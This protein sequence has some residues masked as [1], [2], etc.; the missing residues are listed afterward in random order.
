MIK[1][2]NGPIN[3]A[4]LKGNINGIEKNIYLFMDT[5][6]NLD[7]ETR[8]DSFDSVDISYYLYKMIKE[9]TKP[10]DFFFEIRLSELRQ[11]ITNKRDIYIKE[12][13]N[14]FKSEF[15]IKKTENK[16][17][18]KYSKSNQNVKLHYLDIR[19]HL[20]LFDLIDDVNIHI[21]KYINLLKLNKDIDTENKSKYKDKII[22]YIRKIKNKVKLLT[23]YK[24]EVL[25]SN[26]SDYDKISDT[27]KYYLNKIINK[28][29]DLDLK[30]KINEFIENYYLEVSSNL[31][32]SLYKLESD[33]ENF[34]LEK[35]NS[36]TDI[37]D[38]IK[39]AIIDLY[40]IFTDGFLLRRIL[41]KNYIRRVIIYSGTQHSLN[42]IHFL[43]KYYNFKIIKIHNSVE[44]NTD[45][46]TKQISNAIYPFS[47]YKLFMEKEKK[48]IQCINWEILYGGKTNRTNR[49]K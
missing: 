21:N 38:F 33:I 4:H 18:V 35:I 47:I 26:N 2:I 6:N 45:K 42:Y 49:L 41:D 31:N 1:Y 17:I 39:E 46:L 19:D 32:S 20:N 7:N 28:Y 27:E 9:T 11:P 43:V 37:I 24:N 3:F 34:N 23:Q 44:K 15:V 14:L 48:Y 29:I 5:H 10:L 13:T 36:Y 8:C 40:S 12:V 16:E 30:K 25:Y 22:F